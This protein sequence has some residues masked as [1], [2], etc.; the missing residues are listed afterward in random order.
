MIDLT[1]NP[2]SP[3]ARSHYHVPIVQILSPVFSRRPEREEEEVERERERE[4]LSLMAFV[5]KRK[6]LEK[7]KIVTDSFIETVCKLR[8]VSIKPFLNLETVL[9]KTY[10]NL[11]TVL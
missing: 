2:L 7:K 1:E 9:I 10:I 6:K 5:L 11:Q 3:I 4:S 8:M